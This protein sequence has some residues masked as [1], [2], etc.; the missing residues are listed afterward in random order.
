MKNLR[1]QLNE[2][3]YNFEITKVN[4]RNGGRFLDITFTCTDSELRELIM[5]LDYDNRNTMTETG[6]TF[7]DMLSDVYDNL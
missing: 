3:G 1:D 7:R 2:S 4:K 6:E 5:A